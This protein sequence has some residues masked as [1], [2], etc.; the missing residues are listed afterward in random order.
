MHLMRIVEAGLAA[1]AGVLGVGKQNDWG[2][3]LS[4]I[5][6]ELANRIKISGVRT[7]DEQFYAEAALTI[8]RMRR[9]WRNPTTHVERSYSPERTREI[10]EAVRSFMVHLAMKVSEEW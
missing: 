7:L 3:F 5:D 9:A 10:L 1:L 4:E 2:R 6:K 8:D